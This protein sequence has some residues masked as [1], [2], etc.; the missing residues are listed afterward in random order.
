MCLCMGTM[1]A[2][3]PKNARVQPE[4]GPENVSYA[5]LYIC[6]FLTLIFISLKKLLMFKCGRREKG[7]RKGGF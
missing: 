1:C 3:G 6:I 2:A 5:I 4:P 7:E